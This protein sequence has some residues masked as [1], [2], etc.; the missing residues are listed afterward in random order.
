MTDAQR[1]AAAAELDAERFQQALRA[2]RPRP[3][4]MLIALP[5]ITVAFIVP[6]VVLCSVV[7]QQGILWS[8]TA[9]L[10]AC[11]GV[12]Y[13]TGHRLET[14]NAACPRAGD[15][16]MAALVTFAAGLLLAALALEPG[17][18]RERSLPISTVAPITLVLIGLGVG[19]LIT[20][21][22]RICDRQR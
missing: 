12:L 1:H 19:M 22:K 3:H 6:A 5:V 17:P 9:L 10:T 11:A 21:A 2:V 14:R 13:H 15:Y 20:R 18:W 7:G 4:C 16:M 8:I